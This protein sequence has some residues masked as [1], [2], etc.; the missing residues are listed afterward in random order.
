MPSMPDSDNAI[1]NQVNSNRSRVFRVCQGSIII[2]SS[3]Y[4]GKGKGYGGSTSQIHMLT[5]GNFPGVGL[6][7]N[8]YTAFPPGNVFN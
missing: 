3:I 1:N 2:A 4:G 6:C 7:T 8:L 5:I